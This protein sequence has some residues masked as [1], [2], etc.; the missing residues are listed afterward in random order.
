MKLDSS[1]RILPLNVHMLYVLLFEHYA[2]LKYLYSS[3]NQPLLP[4]VFLMDMQFP[5]R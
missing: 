3:S 1:T 2:T 5:E 4:R